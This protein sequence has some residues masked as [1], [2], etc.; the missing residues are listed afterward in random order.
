MNAAP[1]IRIEPDEKAALAH[2]VALFPLGEAPPDTFVEIAWG[3]PDAAKVNQGR[4]FPVEDM[5]KAAAFACLQNKRGANTYVGASL[6][7]GVPGESGRASTEHFADA[8]HAWVE[9]DD[10]GGEARV[11]AAV[12]ELGLRPNIVVNTGAIPHR[13]AHLY[14]RLTPHATDVADLQAVN[15]A[16]AARL[17][18][19]AVHDPIRILRLA[20]TVNYPPPK[21]VERG[22]VVELTTLVVH[23][24][25]AAASGKLLALCGPATAR[26]SANGT[27]RNGK[28]TGNR[29]ASRTPD[30]IIALLEATL[31]EGQWHNAMRGAIARMIGKKW[32]DDA[33][34]LI[35]APYC[36]NGHS[37]SDLDP[38]IDGARKKWDVPEPPDL[39][40][41][42][43]SEDEGAEPDRAPPEADIIS[44]KAPYDTARLF[45]SRLDTPLRRHRGSFFEWSGSAW[46]EVEEDRLRARLYAFLDRCWKRDAKGDVGPVKPSAPIVNGILDALRAV[47]HLDAILEPPAWL[48]G[49]K[50]ENPR[51]LVACANGLLHLPT[52]RLFPHTSAFFNHNALPFAC[53]LKAPP[54]AQWLAFLKQLW[55][56]NPEAIDTLQEIFGYYLTADTRQQKAFA[57][58]GPKRSGKG[59]I[60]RVLTALLGPVNCAAPTLAGLATNFGLQPLIGKRAA[61]ISD[62]RLGSRADQHTIA[63]RL[64]SISG[65]DSLTIDRKYSSDWTGRLQVRFLIL[66]NELFRLAD[67]S[68]ALAS[69][70]ILLVLTQSF[71]GREDMRLTERLMAELPG[72]LNWAIAG[73]ARLE[74]RGYFQQPASGVE[75]M[76]ELEDL[77]SPIG[78]FL[79]ERCEIGPAYSAN[80]DTVYFAWKSW[81]DTQGRDHAGTKQ[82]FGRDLRAAL[83]GLKT[84]RPRTEYGRVREF[85]GLKL[86]PDDDP[87]PDPDPIPF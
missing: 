36:Q 54:P 5:A 39:G 84:L 11:R 41:P 9:F 6:R 30:E 71:Y 26:N 35:C 70:F 83:P 67:A 74:E 20:G 27:A 18:T 51:E 85:Q 50:G 29:G 19:D 15:A 4:W 23:G 77:T 68:G 40:P 22:Y 48:D 21:K 16:L 58:I 80:V 62:A 46:P 10:P 52:A 38:L 47:A 55:P 13:R 63:E 61:I 59:T 28:G 60:A 33:I 37:D 7:K 25:K 56:D 65:E 66:S 64:L 32:S 8:S 73:W 87:D 14:F 1:G 34:R 45:Q 75:S 53:D 76:Q 72:I 81:C 12:T 2:L 44:L 78:A 86:R 42:P 69:R 57:L 31:V 49:A 43:P 17:G 3:K 79:R 24:T 82:T